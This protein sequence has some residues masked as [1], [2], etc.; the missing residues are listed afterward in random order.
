[1]PNGVFGD[2]LLHVRLAHQKRS[3]LIDCGE[4]QKLP[5]R[6]AHQVTDVLITHA[7]ADHVAGLLSFI[8]SRIGEWPACRIYGPRGIADN[9]AGLLAGIHWDRAGWRA[10]RF[11]VF[12]LHGAVIRRFLVAAARREPDLREEIT[13]TGGCLFSDQHVTIRAIELDHMTPVLAF[14]LKPAANVRIR[15]DRL[16]ALGLEP[17]PW[18]AV[19]KDKLLAGELGESIELPTGEVSTASVLGDELCF[20]EPPQTLVYATDLADT[21]SNRKRLSEFSAG[22]HTLFLEAAFRVCDVEQA[23]RTGH[24]TTRA[25]GEIALRAG[26]E[27]LIPF[28][29]SRR[30]EKDV[31]AVYAEVARVFPNTVLPGGVIA[32]DS[33]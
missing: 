1:M 16:E 30:Y 28:H 11:D 32:A 9:V 29:F 17:G 25:C 8:R 10:P 23:E 5:A 27:Q 13:G 21:P 3:L 26:V 14:S 20:V 24:L 6:I 4:G 7:H 33:S 15:S 22:A 18:L 31:A 2:P 19:F 12:E